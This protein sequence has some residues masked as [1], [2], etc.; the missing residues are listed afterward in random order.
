MLKI[1]THNSA[2][3][4]CGNW[5]SWIF[6]IFSKTQSKTIKEQYEAGSRVF[7]IRIRKI[8]DQWKCAHG[9]WVTKKSA[10]DIFKELNEFEDP[11]SI[12]ITYEGGY[13][14]NEL[15]KAYVQKIKSLY[16]H[17][18]YG[19]VAVKYGKNA[20][21]LKIEYDYILEADKNWIDANCVQGFLPLNGSTW[22][23]YLPIPWLWDKLYKRPHKFNEEIYTYVDFL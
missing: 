19:P 14:N 22:H 17:N 8:N 6:A 16:K 13:E 20:E 11:C 9:F 12:T 21:G 10:E 5:Y 4:E 18:K 23:T 1:A 15:F 2:T 3:G 7:D